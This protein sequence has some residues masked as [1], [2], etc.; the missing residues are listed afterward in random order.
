[1]ATNRLMI[2]A[3]RSDVWAVLGNGW[4]YSNWVVGTSHVRA[5]QPQWP[6]HGA[7]IFHASGAWPAVTRDETEVVEM[8][9]EQ[10]LV[11]IAR[12][13]PFGAAQIELTLRDDGGRCEVT[14]VEHPVSGPGK[15][16]HNPL[17]EAILA[18]RNTESLARL[19]AMS[20]RRTAPAE[21]D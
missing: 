4:G 7:K 17:S 11:L 6:A 16:V 21:A 10:R 3:P 14:L 1:M 15:W 9:D 19:A 18:R 20:E 12:G 5:V 13:G 8:T 2:D